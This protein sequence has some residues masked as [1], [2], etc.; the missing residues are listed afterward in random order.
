M[1]S[2]SPEGRGV[3]HIDGKVTFIDGALPGETVRARYQKRRKRF[4]E[5][6]TV[7]VIHPSRERRAAK[8]PPFWRLWG[9]P[10]AASRCRRT[11]TA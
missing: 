1:D 5:A 6:E 10:L 2:L 11:D 8:M 3:A 7:G 4:D 9:L